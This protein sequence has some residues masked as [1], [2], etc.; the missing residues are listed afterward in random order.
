MVRPCFAHNVF[1]QLTSFGLANSKDPIKP[2][3]DETERIGSS[4]S[5]RTKILF[6]M[7]LDAVEDAG[8]M[9]LTM[10]REVW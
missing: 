2:I 10:Q 6:A 9:Q 1:V 4:A 7:Q 3:T 5:P 8:Q